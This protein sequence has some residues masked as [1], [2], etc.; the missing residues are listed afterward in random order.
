MGEP[1]KRETETVTSACTVPWWLR[2]YP[3]FYMASVFSLIPNVLAGSVGRYILWKAEGRHKCNNVLLKMGFAMAIFSVLTPAFPCNGWKLARCVDEGTFWHQ[4]GDTIK[5]LH[6][7][8]AFLAFTTCATIQM[9]TVYVGWDS[10]SSL[11][12]VYFALTVVG[13][14][15]GLCTLF[16]HYLVYT[17]DELETKTI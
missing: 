13:V 11:Q 8:W 12:K 6:L 4:C 15:P 17:D 16:Y 3:I 7:F 9:I 2:P 1:G 5:N 10:F 14:P